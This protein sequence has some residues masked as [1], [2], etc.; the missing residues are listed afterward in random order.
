MTAMGETVKITRSNNGRLN[1]C[2]VVDA[3]GGVLCE[4]P[5]HG[6]ERRDVI[7]EPPQA[8]LLLFGTRVVVE[9]ES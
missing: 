6:V 1:R 7:G 8:S 4:L 2:V 9:D 5:I 3:H